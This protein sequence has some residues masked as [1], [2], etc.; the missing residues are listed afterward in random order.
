MR[1]WSRERSVDLTGDIGSSRPF[2]AH[3]GQCRGLEGFQ[4]LRSPAIGAYQGEGDRKV[5]TTEN[6]EVV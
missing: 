4:V 1:N 2:L 5:A 6:Y 3:W